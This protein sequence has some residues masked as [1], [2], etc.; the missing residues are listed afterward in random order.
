MVEKPRDPIGQQRGIALAGI[1]SAFGYCVSEFSLRHRSYGGMSQAALDADNGLSCIDGDHPA[2]SILRRGDDPEIALTEVQV[3]RE[4]ERSDI[5]VNASR[6]PRSTAIRKLAHQLRQVRSWAKFRPALKYPS[7]RSRVD[8]R[9]SGEFLVLDLRW[10]PP[11]HADGLLHI[12]RQHGRAAEAM[13]RQPS[14]YLPA[15]K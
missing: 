3:A 2:A 14:H 8:F 1:I 11:D 13:E 4:Q 15:D 6:V 12:A 10:I 7:R 5:G 9:A